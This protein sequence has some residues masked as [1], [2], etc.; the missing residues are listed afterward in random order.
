MIAV[1]ALPEL[2]HRQV[3]SAW[4][5]VGGAY[6]HF[7]V[8]AYLIVMPLSALAVSSYHAPVSAIITAVPRIS[9]WF[10]GSYALL[11]ASSVAAAIVLEPVLRLHIA[12]RAA[13]DPQWAA[14]ASSRRVAR[15]IAEGVSRLG[16]EPASAL[17]ALRGERW[18]HVDERFQALSADL[19]EVVRTSCVAL[20][21][22]PVDRRAAIIRVSAESLHRI[23]T[24]LA[25]LQAERGRLNEGDLNTVARYVELRHGSSDFASDDG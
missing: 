10:L 1:D 23:E 9:A 21:T 4:R 22:A 18:D 6:L 13:R 14:T 24:A 2:S 12:R 17:D 16:P 19:A 3:I 5:L 11:A 25:A 8:P 20:A 15:A 7:A